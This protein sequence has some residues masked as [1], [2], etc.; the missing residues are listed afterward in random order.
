[1]P[2][3]SDH[4]QS[5][6]T[7]SHATSPTRPRQ[8]HSW[9]KGDSHPRSKQDGVYIPLTLNPH[10]FTGWAGELTTLLSNLPLVTRVSPHRR[11]T[12][13]SPNPLWRSRMQYCGGFQVVW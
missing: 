7:Q 3:R 6:Q 8:V 9:I 11:T 2:P 4:L 13:R 1:M 12:A 5:V 10:I